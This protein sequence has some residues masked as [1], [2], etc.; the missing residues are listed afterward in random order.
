MSTVIETPG[1]A[2]IDINLLPWREQ[3]RERRTRRF[4]LWLFFSVIL[5]LAIG[6]LC[7]FYQQYQLDR[8]NDDIAYIQ[9]RT[10]HL[11]QDINQGHVLEDKR[12]Q[13]QGRIE[14][15]R[16][17]QFSRSQTVA[18]FQALTDT[19]SDGVVYDRI[20]RHDGQ[21]EISGLA[22]T[23]RQVSDQMRALSSAPV[24]GEP[25]LLDVRAEDERSNRRRFNL[26]VPEHPLHEVPTS[27]E[28]LP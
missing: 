13:M 26:Q 28:A 17:L 2:Q 16:Q 20:N 3:A 5:G 22:M 8:I 14:L 12:H 15:I 19:L 4:H 9:Q 21:L 1:N 24:L 27:V 11:E 10:E 6:F 18:L 25:L 7:Q 23:N